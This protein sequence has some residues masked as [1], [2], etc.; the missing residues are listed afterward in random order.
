MSGRAAEMEPELLERDRETAA[1]S[2]WLAEVQATATGR[3]VL[4][5]GE[6]GVGKTALVHDLCERDPRVEVLRGACDPL[7]TPAAMGPVADVAATLGG[8]T[9][10]LIG[11][12]ARPYEVAR[13]LLR[14]LSA[15]PVTIVVIEDLHWV[16]DGTLDVLVY[17]VR[18]IK[19]VPALVIG[20]YRE[21]DLPAEHPFRTALGRL[22][23]APRF[24]RLSLRP[25]SRAAVAAL[26]Q[27]A[28]RDPEGLFAASGGNPFY[29]CE[30]L[31]GPPGELP[32]T[33]RDAVLAR[34]A[35]LDTRARGL[36]DLVAVI[37]AEADLWLLECASES[38]L[39]GLDDC[40]ERGLLVRH[41][42]AVR[43][44]HELVRVVLERELGPGA[45]ATLHRRLLGA[46]ELAGAVPAR[47]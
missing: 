18:R 6:A 40:V 1:L 34:A 4:I 36:L 8:A 32:T 28:G 9:A 43:F 27:R 44:R 15:R 46:L 7:I 33:L 19:S 41:A 13:A 3:I 45:A 29:V 35:P 47:L 24:S 21:D 38:G 37:P 16:D 26:A 11:N 12:G 23:T 17:L 2:G 5:A 31:A 22:A 25:L 42:G 10:E 39:A 20:T 14:E 30:L